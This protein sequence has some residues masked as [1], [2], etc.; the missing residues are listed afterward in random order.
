MKAIRCFSL[1]KRCSRSSAA[2][3]IFFIFSFSPCY[4][5][6]GDSLRS[7]YDLDDP[8]NPDCP[9]HQHQRLADQELRTLQEK[10]TPPLQEG[11]RK[12]DQKSSSSLKKSK[13]K[14]LNFGINSL[15]IFNSGRVKRT[16]RSRSWTKAIASYFK[17]DI[18]ACTRF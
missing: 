13:F 3:F 10:Q 4:A 15:L 9:C 17:R 6:P 18:A 5:G 8:R 11:Q 7:I 12:T 16:K 2:S 14:K 1:V